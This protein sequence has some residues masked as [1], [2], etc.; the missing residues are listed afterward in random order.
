MRYEII[1]DEGPHENPCE[2]DSWEVVSF[3]NRHYNFR[4]PEDVGVRGMDAY[5]Q[6]Q[7]IIGMQ[8]KI[9]RNTAFVLSYYEHGQCSWFLKGHGLPGT[10]CVWDGVKNAGLLIWRGNAN[11]IGKT[12]EDRERFA[13]HFIEIYTHWCN[14]EVYGYRILDDDGEEIDS[15]WGYYGYEITEQEAKAA[16]KSLQETESATCL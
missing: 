2:E 13:M 5:G 3:G 7:F 12:P 14:G 10:D 16:M 15:C 4:R 1:L 6:L 9:E 8:R 11:D